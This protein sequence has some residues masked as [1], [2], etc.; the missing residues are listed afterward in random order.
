M[1]DYIS[2]PIEKEKLANL[3]LQWIPGNE[4]ERLQSIKA[5]EAV[6]LPTEKTSPQETDST[7]DWERLEE[8]TGGDPDVEKKILDMFKDNLKSDIS[9]LQKSFDQENYEEWD[10]WVHK[11]YGACSHVGASALADACDKG[12]SIP[13]DDIAQIKQIHTVILHEYENVHKALSKKA[14]N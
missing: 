6:L 5:K 13:S 1:D 8:F 7:I 10:S 14:L 3:L 11:L 4:N 9:D 2:K 12:Q